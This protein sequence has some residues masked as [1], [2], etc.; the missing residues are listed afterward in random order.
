MTTILREPPRARRRVEPFIY[1]T[2]PQTPQEPAPAVEPR[3]VW[4]VAVACVVGP[5]VLALQLLGYALAVVAVPLLPFLMPLLLFP[6]VLACGFLI[7]GAG[8]GLAAL[9]LAKTAL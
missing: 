5:V 1:Q 3:S 2:P 7:L 8:G 9:G 6:V 4:D